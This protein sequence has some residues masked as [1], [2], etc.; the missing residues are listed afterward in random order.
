MAGRTFYEDSSH[1]R[2]TAREQSLWNLAGVFHTAI[3]EAQVV[4]ATN[5]RDE[6]W[7]H[8]QAVTV[9]EELVKKLRYFDKFYNV[10]WPKVHLNTAKHY[11]DAKGETIAATGGSEWKKYLH[12]QFQQR[13]FFPGM[14]SAEELANW[15]K[16]QE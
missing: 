7:D 13:K 10:E 4:R 5:E 1:A 2:Q 11:L 3:I 15:G 9:P 16:D 6:V 8:A 12:P 14:Y